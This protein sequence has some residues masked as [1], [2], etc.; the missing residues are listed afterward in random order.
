VNIEAMLRARRWPGPA[1]KLTPDQVAEIR[2]EAGRR[3]ESQRAI[4]RRFNM[5]EASIS[6]IANDRSWRAEPTK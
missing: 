2:R 4:A 1:A 6:R 3:A 5:S